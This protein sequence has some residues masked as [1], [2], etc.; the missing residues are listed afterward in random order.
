MIQKTLLALAVAGFMASGS[1]FAQT[2]IPITTDPATGISTGSFGGSSGTRNY[3]FEI[4]G[5]GLFDFTAAV[6]S[7]NTISPGFSITNATFDT[8]SF[9]QSLNT[10]ATGVWA[11]GFNLW[12]YSATNITAGTHTLSVTGTGTTAGALGGF[13]FTSAPIVSAV[14]AVPEPATIT[15]MLAGLALVGGMQLRR[16]KKLELAG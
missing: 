14:P 16:K 15:M 6:Y 13:Q 11:P 8:N 5:T 12:N 4:M 3:T 9:T 7:L 2:T 1:A 10:P